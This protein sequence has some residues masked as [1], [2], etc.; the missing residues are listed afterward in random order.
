MAERPDLYTLLPV[1]NPFVVPGARFREVSPAEQPQHWS[2]WQMPSLR[3]A[4]GDGV[5]F[6]CQ[7]GGPAGYGARGGGGGGGGVGAGA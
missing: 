6:A 3:S 4:A 2:V 5:H 7:C 1:P